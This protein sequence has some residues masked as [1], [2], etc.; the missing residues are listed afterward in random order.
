MRSV[1]RGACDAAQDYA[2]HI[3]TRVIA[4]MLGVNE[5]DGDLFRRW[6]K[7][8]LQDGIHSNEPVV[9]AITE[10]TIFF[11]Q[12]IEKRRARNFE[13]D[14]LICYVMKQ[15]DHEGNPVTDAEGIGTM[16]LLLIA[17]IDTT[18][19]AIGASIWHLATHDEDRRRLVAEPALM[20][21]AVEELLRAYSPVTMAR[22]VK[23][24][25]TVNG[26]PMKPGAMILLSF[27]AANRDPEVFPDADKVILDREENRHAAFG[28]G[29]HRCVGSNLARMELRTAIEVF[30]ERIPSSGST[31]PSRP[32]GPRAPS[33][34]R[35][36]CHCCSE[37]QRRDPRGRRLRRGF[38]GSPDPDG[39]GS[40]DRGQPGQRA[41]PL[42]K[43]LGAAGRPAGS[44]R[45]VPPARAASWPAPQGPA[46][47]RAAGRSPARHPSSWRRPGC[48][49]RSCTGRSGCPRRTGAPRHRARTST[50]TRMHRSAGPVPTGAADSGA[51]P[52][53]A[54]R[55]HP[56]CGW[57]RPP[58]SVASARPARAIAARRPYCVRNRRSPGP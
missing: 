53:A 22:E 47:S 12:E 34:G 40:V 8:A 4:R 10:M 31:R 52:P 44:A 42:P 28:L 6:I 35:A 7:L 37:P 49:R 21:T 51:R 14:D 9:Q 43:V 26:C 15:K 58:R 39:R 27:P 11:K 20:D 1:A 19:S 57:H 50:A 54:A 16:R 2:Q 56:D 18:W 17:G 33:A 30:L 38:G 45:R 55:H 5:D 48:G 32:P 24:D 29:I 23:K 36:T 46:A 25:V 41:A 3:P 13:G